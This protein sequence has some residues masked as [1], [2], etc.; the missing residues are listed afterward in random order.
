MTFSV[1]G[2]AD[3]AGGGA[4]GEPRSLSQAVAPRR[5]KIAEKLHGN[6]EGK[7]REVVI[8]PLR[9]AI[10][11]KVSAVIRRYAQL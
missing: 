6:D 5:I 8:G 2:L 4:A 1:A 3:P 11:G 9:L 7:K 10:A